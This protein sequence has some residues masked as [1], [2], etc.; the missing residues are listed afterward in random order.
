MRAWSCRLFGGFELTGP[1]GPVVIAGA[2]PR[3]LLAVLALAPEGVAREHAIGLL[4]PDRGESQARHSLRQ[5]LTTLRAALPG[6]IEADTERIA[7]DGIAV[8]VRAFDRLGAAADAESWVRAVELYAGPLLDGLAVRA[9]AFEHWL[10]AERGRR[11][12]AAVDL[13]H[14]L[15]RMAAEAGDPDRAVAL[16]RRMLRLD[17]AHEP[18]CSLLMTGLSDLGERGAALQCYRSLS[19]HLRR[20]FGARPAAAT[21]AAYRAVRDQ[22]RAVATPE[23]PV[24]AVL[25]FAAD[26][27]ERNGLIAR[28]I[29][30]ELVTLLGKLSDLVVIDRHAAQGYPA[31]IDGE[32]AAREL[33]AR[34]LLRGTVRSADERLRITALLL[35][36]GRG[37]VLWSERFDRVPPGDVFAVQDAIADEV[38]TSLQVKLT[39]GE[40]ARLWRRSTDDIEAWLLFIEG[41]GLVR[42][43]TRERN[44]Q[45]RGSL[46]RA[47]RRDPRFAPAWVFLGWSHVLDLRS[48]WCAD[49]AAALAAAERCAETAL[50][51]D[52]ELA[53]AYSLRGGIDLSVGRHDQAVAARRRAVGLAPNHSESHA[54]LAAGLYYAGPQAEAEQHIALAERLSPYYPG[55]YPIVRGWTR[56]AAGRFADAERAFA[57]SCDRLPDNLVGYAYLIVTQ[58]MAGRLETARRT[59]ETA[60]RR[61]P[62]LTLSHARR[63]LLY[64]DPDLVEHRMGCL[65]RAGVSG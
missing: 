42:G 1:E 56:L 41:L 39:E 28:G 31:D 11:H 53:D 25:P 20:E 47:L 4:W 2:M 51:L 29:A 33:G 38:A 52:P 61:S 63:W 60:T 13:L 57:E 21:E 62:D 26:T 65:R 32:T 10:A 54:W 8:D 7:L 45:G 49:P 50:G 5:A 37:S 9:D 35:D 22:P 55:W 64:R 46:E 48:G 23:R 17:P 43:I 14:R 27:G 12:D 18:A 34:Y 59:A 3:A 16:A 30:E 44:H 36:A 58:V 24:I 15:A 40:Q 19:E 6:R